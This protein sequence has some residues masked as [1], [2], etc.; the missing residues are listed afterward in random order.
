MKYII[1]IFILQ[2]YLGYFRQLR[3]LLDITDINIKKEQI[4]KLIH[5]P[6]EQL[7]A[8]S[9]TLEAELVLSEFCNNFLCPRITPAVKNTLIPF[10]QKSNTFPYN[11]VIKFLNESKNV[12]TTN[13][14]FYCILAL[15]PCN[16]GKFNFF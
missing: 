9:S 7:S 2:I 10:L 3:R 13:S 12:D 16:H 4:L 6:F 1:F 11:D 5:R 15:E 14:L 8:I